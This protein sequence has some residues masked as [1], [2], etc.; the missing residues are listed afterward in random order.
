MFEWHTHEKLSNQIP[1]KTYQIGRHRNVI[2]L[3]EKK[4]DKENKSFARLQVIQH[5]FNT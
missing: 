3:D 1:Q 5:E 2:F 4:N